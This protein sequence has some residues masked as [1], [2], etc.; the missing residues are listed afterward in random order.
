MTLY[1]NMSVSRP[2]LLGL[3]II[4]HFQ[5]PYHVANVLYILFAPLWKPMPPNATL[6]VLSPA[7]IAAHSAPA[8]MNTARATFRVAHL[9]IKACV[10]S[11]SATPFSI[12]LSS[13]DALSISCIFAVSLSFTG[14]MNRKVKGTM[15]GSRIEAARLSLKAVDS[16][17]SV[18][19][20]T[21]TSKGVLA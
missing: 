11:P 20:S 21:H 3:N 1:C 14:A 10:V 5:T 8:A 19:G 17:S 15:Q 7:A 2:V 13:S 16:L 4:L 9:S 6:S 12:A 18:S